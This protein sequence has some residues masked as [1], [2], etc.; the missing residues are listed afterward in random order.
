MEKLDDLQIKQMAAEFGIDWKLIKTVLAIESAGSGFDSKTG[1]IKIQFEPHIFHR[2]LGLKKI[3]SSLKLIA[4]TL[5]RVVVGN[6]TIENKVDVQ[7]KEWTAFEAALKINE[8]AA[9][10]A[11]SWGLGQIC[12]FNHIA[13]GYKTA[14]EMVDS[15]KASEYNQLKGMMNFIKYHPKMFAALKVMDWDTFAR[16]YNGPAYKKFSYDTKLRNTYNSLV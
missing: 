8:D 7:S 10:K 2:E 4:G 3:T 14:K 1:K 9:Y 15:F 6:I 13:S 11:T 16:Y 12:G 5:Y